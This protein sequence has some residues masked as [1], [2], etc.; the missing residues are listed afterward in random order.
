MSSILATGEVLPTELRLRILKCINVCLND[1][2]RNAFGF[3]IQSLNC[4]MEA[5]IECKA[6][7]NSHFMKV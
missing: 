2:V 7:H 4:L 1:K 6:A 5:V 3:V